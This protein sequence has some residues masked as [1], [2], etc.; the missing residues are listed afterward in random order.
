[1]YKV[2]ISPLAKQDIKDAA[3][4]YNDKQAGLG[5]RFTNHIRLKL[6]SLKKNPYIAAN[7]YDEVRTAVLDTFPFM[8]HYI[9]DE[10]K[11]MIILLAA[12]H[13]SLS[14]DVWKKA[15]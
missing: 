7:R 15:R 8:A 12:L 13:T 9:I 14:P 4:W 5:K 10:D 6:D 2:I 1:M 3:H 11:K